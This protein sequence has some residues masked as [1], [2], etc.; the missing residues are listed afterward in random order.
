MES[1]RK[2]LI[3]LTSEYSLSENEHAV[4]HINVDYKNTGSREI[5]DAGP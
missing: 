5:L 3:V 4:F 1:R 2:F